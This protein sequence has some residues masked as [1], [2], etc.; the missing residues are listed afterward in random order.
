MGCGQPPPP[1]AA[2]CDQTKVGNICTIAGDGA[3]GYF[4]DDGPAL[5]AQFSLPQDTLTAAD[6][7]IYILDWNNHRIRKLTLAGTVVA[8]AGRGELG[9]GLDS[10]P[11]SDFNH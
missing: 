2:V 5:K 4:G 8:V 1:P 6:G 10:P 9:G 3:N 11:D 7:T